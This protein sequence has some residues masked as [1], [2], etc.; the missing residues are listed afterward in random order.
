MSWSY[1]D[2]EGRQFEIDLVQEVLE[3][4]VAPDSEEDADAAAEH[5]T[6]LNEIVSDYKPSRGHFETFVLQRFALIGEI[7][8][9]VPEPPD[10]D[11]RV[12]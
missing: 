9:G 4:I 5:A 8:G 2:H 1:T 6:R 10:D 12:Y 7:E 11:G 3:F